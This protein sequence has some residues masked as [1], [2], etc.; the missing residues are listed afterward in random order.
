MSGRDAGRLDR[1]ADEGRAQ[2]LD[3]RVHVADLAVASQLTAL[4]DAFAAQGPAVG[5]A[6]VAGV[7]H[8]IT[9]QK[10]AEED[11]DRVWQVNAGGPARLLRRLS[12]PGALAPGARGLLVG[13]IVASRGN[14]GQ[15]AYAAAKG[16]LLDFLPWAPAG[17]RLNV[18]LPP[19]V[20]SPLL[21]GL[22]PEARERLFR[23]RLL[24]DPDPALSCAAAATW[25]LSDA[26][27][28]VHGQVFHADSR[29][30]GLGFD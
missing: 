18:L 23:T 24:D 22:S 2:G 12:G 11:W 10:L 16:A 29:V 21:A 15:A 17:L 26:A 6:W 30:S 7:N 25:L 27:A 9:V 1:L 28:Y 5:F 4:L 3:V 8:D 20:E 14:H 19:L 13:S